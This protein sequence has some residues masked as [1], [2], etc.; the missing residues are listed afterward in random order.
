M[1]IGTRDRN[2][3]QRV[4]GVERGATCSTAM[5]ESFLCLAKHFLAL[6]K[7]RGGRCKIQ[8]SQQIEEDRKSY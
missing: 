2:L 6:L 8:L 5:E 7:N 4:G 1:I 3:G